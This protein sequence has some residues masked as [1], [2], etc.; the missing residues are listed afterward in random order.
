MRQFDSILS[1]QRRYLQPLPS[2]MKE[3]KSM[4]LVTGDLFLSEITLITYSCIHTHIFRVIV[5]TTISAMLFAEPYLRL[6]STL[7]RTLPQNRMNHEA[8]QEGL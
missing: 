1:M 3:Q 7:I 5:P 2:S 8:N 6:P 4:L